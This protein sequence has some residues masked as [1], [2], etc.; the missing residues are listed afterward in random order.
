MKIWRWIKLAFLGPLAYA[1]ILGVWLYEV[2][3]DE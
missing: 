3:T 1:I 2:I